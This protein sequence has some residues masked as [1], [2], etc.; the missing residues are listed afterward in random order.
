MKDFIETLIKMLVDNPDKVEVTEKNGEHT[1]ICEVKVGEGDI[2]KI[3]GKKGQTARSLRTL[4]AAVSK[5]MGKRAVF[6]I[7]E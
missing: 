3:I 5:K 1:V 2:G 4:I 7:I 6:E